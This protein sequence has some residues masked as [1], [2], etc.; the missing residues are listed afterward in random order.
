[1]TKMTIIIHNKYSQEFTIA[2]SLLNAAKSEIQRHDTNTTTSRLN[3]M[4]DYEILLIQ[5]T[6]RLYEWPSNVVPETETLI[7]KCKQALKANTNRETTVPRTEILS[8]CAALLLN[9]N[10]T[11]ELLRAERRYPLSDLFTAIAAVVHE[12]EHKTN[13]AK[14]TFRDAWDLIAQMFTNNGGHSN[15]NNRRTHQQPMDVDDSSDTTD[16]GNSRNNETED[17]SIKYED[18]NFSISASGSNGDKP[19]DDDLL[20]NNS[21]NSPK[22]GLSSDRADS[23]PFRNTNRNYCHGNDGYGIRDSLS[24]IVNTNLL[25]FIQK[26]RDPLRK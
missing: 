20:E 6:Q 14:K 22:P 18:Q 5:T 1:M 11:T 16:L 23:N 13:A 12:L 3:K 2:I 25:P 4:M 7:T 10:E 8:A 19:T 26:L 21:N 15:S 24:V 17:G 9:L